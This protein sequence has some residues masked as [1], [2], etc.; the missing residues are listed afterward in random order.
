MVWLR[1]GSLG[2]L[3]RKSCLPLPGSVWY[4]LSEPT[5]PRED[6]VVSPLKVASSGS[7]TYDRS[8]TC[9]Q[10]EAVTAAPGPAA[11]PLPT[12][13]RHPRGPPCSPWSPR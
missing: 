13:S 6:G 8:S 11:F 5:R 10:S 9:G 12:L 2:R 7:L 3:R 4:L 1:W